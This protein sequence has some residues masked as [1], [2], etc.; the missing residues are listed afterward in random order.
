MHATGG[1][2]K[3]AGVRGADK[4]SEVFKT[5]YFHDLEESDSIFRMFPFLQRSVN[6]NST[7]TACTSPTLNTLEP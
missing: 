7:D 2:R 6:M 5:I 4:D 3:A 1:R